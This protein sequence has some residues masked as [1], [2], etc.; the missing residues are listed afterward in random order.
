MRLRLALLNEDLA[1]R[2]GVSATLCSYILTWI[3]LL[4]KVL[5]KA[6]VLWPLKESIRED[7]PEIFLKSGY[8]K[9]R[10]IIDYAEVFIERPKSLSA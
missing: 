10:V 5:V 4:R 3:K 8:G 9:Y 6:L 7:L 1:E 2:F